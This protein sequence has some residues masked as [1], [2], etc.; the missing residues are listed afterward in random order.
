MG[1]S[2]LAPKIDG[3]EFCAPAPSKRVFIESIAIAIGEE[4]EQGR[5]AHKIVGAAKS[6]LFSAVN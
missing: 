4:R 3:E 6:R 5:A 2:S 1:H